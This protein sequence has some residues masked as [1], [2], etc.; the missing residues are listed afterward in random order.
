VLPLAMLLLAASPAGAKPAGQPPATADAGADLSDEEFVKAFGKARPRKGEKPTKTTAYVP[1]PPGAGGPPALE[2]LEPKHVMDVVL[3]ARADIKRC[4][5]GQPNLQ[6][7]KST[8]TLQWSIGLDGKVTK[9][10]TVGDELKQTYVAGCVTKLVK[11]WQFPK[12]TVPA[13]PVVFPFKL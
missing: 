8:L 7:G 5:D 3:A 13:D 9:V 10:E 12:H 1:P 4:A 6:R 11:R 2:K